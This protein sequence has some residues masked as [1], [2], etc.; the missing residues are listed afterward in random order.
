VVSVD[1]AAFAFIRHFSN[2]HSISERC[3]CNFY[4]AV[5]GFSSEAN[6]TVSSAKVVYLRSHVSKSAV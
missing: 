3:V 1:F 5:M 6:I 4:D 2:H